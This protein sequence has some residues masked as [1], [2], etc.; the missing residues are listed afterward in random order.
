MDTRRSR[1]V[2]MNLPADEIENL[3]ILEA[4]QHERELDE[5]KQ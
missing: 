2:I 5:H 3:K 4:A 1:G